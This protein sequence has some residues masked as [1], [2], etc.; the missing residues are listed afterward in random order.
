LGHILPRLEDRETI[1]LKLQLRG[2]QLGRDVNLSSLAR[3]TTSY[4]GCD[5]KSLCV[6][7]AMVALYD[8]LLDSD[9]NLK[10]QEIKKERNEQAAEPKVDGKGADIE[11]VCRKHHRRC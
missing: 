8:E 3:M 4:M 10:A 11:D 7:A 1:L 2:E 9:G 5:L 6:L